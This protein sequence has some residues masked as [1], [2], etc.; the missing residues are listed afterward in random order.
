MKSA[1]KDLNVF[2]LKL[3]HQSRRHHFAKDKNSISKYFIAKRHS[4]IRNFV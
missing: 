1:W 4:K 2:A 3:S